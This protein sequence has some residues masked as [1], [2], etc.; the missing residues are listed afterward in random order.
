MMLGMQIYYRQS[1]PPRIIMWSLRHGHLHPLQAA[2]C[3]RNSRLVVDEDEAQKLKNYSNGR[4]WS[5]LCSV[6]FV[7]ESFILCIL[8]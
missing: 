8:W 1:P 6:H 4:R 5:L 7:Y 2:N 3:C